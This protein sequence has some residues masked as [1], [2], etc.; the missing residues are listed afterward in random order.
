[1]RPYP[2]HL[3]SIYLALWFSFQWASGNFARLCNRWIGQAAIQR[4]QLLSLPFPKT[5]I[6]EQRKIAARLNQ[7]LMLIEKTR[8]AIEQQ[9]LMLN[10]FR[11]ALLRSAFL[12]MA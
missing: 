4:K 12:E 5:S 3:D 9:R 1:L 6:S 7:E 2:D 8:E 11:M 10:E